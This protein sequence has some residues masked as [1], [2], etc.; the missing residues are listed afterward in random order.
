[1]VISE[2]GDV[3]LLY[4]FVRFFGDIYKLVREGGND[5]V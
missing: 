3:L 4:I 2:L 1:M 5:R